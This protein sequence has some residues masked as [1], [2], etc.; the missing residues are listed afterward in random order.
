[1]QY[2]KE[3]GAR[4]NYRV[5]TLIRENRVSCFL[6]YGQMTLSGT[7]LPVNC[8]KWVKSRGKTFHGFLRTM[9]LQQWSL[10]QQNGLGFCLSIVADNISLCYLRQITSSFWISFCFICKSKMTVPGYLRSTSAPHSV[11]LCACYLMRQT[12]RSSNV[13]EANGKNVTQK[14]IKWLPVKMS[15]GNISEMKVNYFK[16]LP[17]HKLQTFLKVRILSLRNNYLQIR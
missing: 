10:L 7:V 14:M 2:L 3:R 17:V 4:E 12:T 9:F 13:I 11:I 16:A 6:D 15:L 1:M 5:Y 8:Q